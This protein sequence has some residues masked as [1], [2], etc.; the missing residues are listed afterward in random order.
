LAAGA[1][2]SKRTL[3]SSAL[4]AGTVARYELI[5]YFASRRFL[6]LLAVVLAI[7]LG[8][9]AVAAYEGTSSFGATPVA[10]Y[11]TWYLGGVSST[12]VVVFCAI[13]FGGDS[14]SGEF[15][16]KSG[17]F[18]VGNPVSRSAIYAGKYLGAL[19]ASL[20][21]VTVYT[22]IAAANG[23]LYFGAL[24]VQFLE[25]LSFALVFLV[26]A[27]S[28]VFSFS[29]LFKNSA[30]SILVASILMLFG[31]FIISA[32]VGG[33]AGSEPW[34]SL[35]Y[36]SDIIGEVLNPSGYPQHVSTTS[37]GKLAFN[38]TVPEGLA[39]MGAYLAISFVLGLIL[40]S[41]KEFS[42]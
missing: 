26:A 40:F 21:V 10:F 17:F 1:H 2:P 19:V 39:I 41:R 4:Q 14:I 29:S 20:I 38:A 9:T 31:L 13:F 32:L 30:T 28:L 42:S 24:P 16:N 5:N 15:Q 36:G 12:Y 34:F 11:S 8:T 7:A 3:P 18:L 33:M 23:L 22:A 37:A 25:S 27:L 6:A 35:T